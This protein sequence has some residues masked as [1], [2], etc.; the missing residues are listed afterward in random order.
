LKFPNLNMRI[1]FNCNKEHPTHQ[2]WYVTTCVILGALKVLSYG[3]QL[4]DK[5]NIVKCARQTMCNCVPCHLPHIL[6][7]K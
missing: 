4:L 5:M 3:V 7:P 6:M 2:M 1:M